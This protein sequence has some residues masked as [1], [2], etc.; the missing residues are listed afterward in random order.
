[1]TPTHST[2]EAVRDL[3]GIGFGPTNLALAVALEEAAAPRPSA[4]FLE[5]RP[6]LAWHPGMLIEDATMQVSFLKDLA[7]L[8][9]PRSA[10][11]FLSYLQDRGRLVDFVNRKDF[12]PSRLEFHDYLEW[13]AARVAHQVRYGTEVVAVRPVTARQTVSAFDVVARRTDGTE[14]TERARNVV[15]GTGLVPRLP[16]GVTGSP[17]VWHSA[18]L[19]SRLRE[20]GERA[21]GSFAVVG[22]GQSAA[23]VA[24]HLHSRFPHSEVRCLLPRYGYSPADDSPFA[25]RVFDPEAVDHFYGA[26]PAV[27]E[28]FYEQ[29]G[30]TNYAVVD[31]DLINDLYRRSYQEDVR[32]RKRLHFEPMSRVVAAHT[33]PAGV[34]LHVDRLLE[35]AEEHLDVDIAVFATGYHPMDPAAVLGPTAELCKRDSAGRLRVGRDYRVETSADVTAGIYLQGG[36]EHTHGIS[37]SLLSNVAVRAGEIL[38]SIAATARPPR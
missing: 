5:K 8:R 18:E 17:R 34:R 1:M 3:V 21:V 26:V 20:V 23:E 9:N 19:L 28:R 6:W 22:A 14:R 35:D 29:H 36:V 33:G 12:F 37:A 10:F 30:N 4:L 38:S 31:L 32:G 2:E 15:I 13:A 11:G 16:T 24:A 25:N 7:T 27:R